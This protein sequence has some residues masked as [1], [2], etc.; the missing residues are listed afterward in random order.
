MVSGAL[1]SGVFSA[2]TGVLLTSSRYKILLPL[3]SFHYSSFWC[4]R[5]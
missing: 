2:V 4:V 5:N 3:L 1:G